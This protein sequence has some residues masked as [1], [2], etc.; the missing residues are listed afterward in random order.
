MAKLSEK[1]QAELEN[2]TK[3]LGEI[4][5]IKDKKKKSTAE[6]AGL[7]TFYTISTAELKTS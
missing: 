5:K 2:I 3:V 7:A 4:N 1:I 6:L